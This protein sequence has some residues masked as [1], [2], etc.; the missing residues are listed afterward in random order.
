MTDLMVARHQIV[1]ESARAVHR[2]LGKRRPL[3]QYEAALVGE[4]RMHG[5]GIRENKNT[6]I[7]FGG[8][9]V[10]V[11]LSD[12]IIDGEILIEL[13]HVAGLTDSEKENFATFVKDFE[14]QR[15]YLMNFAGDD[16]E[17]ETFPAE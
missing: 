5:I 15:G 14:Y 2:R 6:Q 12:I 17:V 4:L 9:S 11:Y 1:V 3:E 13:K 10:G 8:A 7:L 16:L